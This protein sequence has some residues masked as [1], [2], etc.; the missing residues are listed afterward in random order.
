MIR[1]REIDKHQPQS[2]IFQASEST[3][4]RYLGWSTPHCAIDLSIPNNRYPAVTSTSPPHAAVDNRYP[5]TDQVVLVSFVATILNET[6]L[7][8]SSTVQITREV[9]L[10][11]LD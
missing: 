5:A 9:L 8:M 7:N 3:D 2:A 11:F 10:A 4:T 6:E 1:C